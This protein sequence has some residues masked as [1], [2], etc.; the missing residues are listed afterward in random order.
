MKQKIKVLV[1]FFCAILFSLNSYSQPKELFLKNQKYFSTIF[2]ELDANKLKNAYATKSEGEQKAQKSARYY[3]KAERFYKIQQLPIAERKKRR[4]KKKETRFLKKASK[5]E[6]KALE[7][8]FAANEQIKDVYYGNLQQGKD[9]I[10]RKLLLRLDNDFKAYLDSAVLQKSI[11]S[12]NIIEKARA[13]NNAY[14]YENKALLY[15]EYKFAVLNNDTKIISDLEKYFKIEKN[16]KP[17]NVVPKDT[18]TPPKNPTV[19]PPKDS[20]TTTTTTTVTTTTNTTNNNDGT[21]TTDSTTSTVTTNTVVTNGDYN[22][23]Q[24]KYLFCSKNEKIDEELYY[25]EKE[26]DL[27]YEYYT[28]GK[29]GASQLQEVEKLNPTIAQYEQKIKNEKDFRQKRSLISK[30]RELTNQQLV[31]KINALKNY[32][33]A[34]KDYYYCRK[35]HYSDNYPTKNAKIVQMAN[36]YKKEADKYYRSCDKY[37]GIAKSKDGQEKYDAYKYA[38]NQIKT[39]LQYQENGLNVQFKTDTY[40]V[41]PTHKIKASG[42]KKTTKKTAQKS[43]KKTDAKNKKSSNTITGMWKYSSTNQKP[44]AVSAPRGTVYRVR[45]GSSKYLLPTNE[46]KK[47][48]PVY[49]ETTSNTNTKIFYVGDYSQKSE[50]QTVL[51]ELKNKGYSD[52]YVVEYQNGKRSNAVYAKQQTHS[53]TSN[54]K[55]TNSTNIVNTKYLLYVIRLGTFKTEKTAAQLGN[56]SKIYHKILSDGRI[57]YFAGP[58]YSYDAASSHLPTV[59]QNGFSDAFVEAYNNGAKIAISKAKKIEANVNSNSN[60][61]SNTSKTTS[62]NAIFR[63][64]IGSFSDYL[65]ND[66]VTQKFGNVKSISDIHTH[67]NAK[68]LIVYSVGETNSYSNAKQLRQK[69]ANLGYKDCFI[70]AFINGEQVAL[71]KAINK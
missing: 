5:I 51:N 8:C 24:D 26:E 40:V 3:A 63:V 65:S 39:A 43:T 52:A 14:F 66:A 42:A 32:V 61:N 1:I 25:S 57:Q 53:N 64:Q 29:S 69:V 30:K 48:E 50:A 19:T 2:S 47:Y 38:N 17:E 34:N 21:Q 62:S 23:K 49:Y 44:V 56:F 16:K 46:L 7:T 31:Y 37:I 22:I 67:Q 9:N 60:S 4:A 13:W 33:K 6:V 59:K 15:M 41:V 54:V 11:N 55:V 36:F 12:T 71:Q 45:V 58:Y 35:N 20:T 28:L 27:L 70:I 18:V 10:N 68:G